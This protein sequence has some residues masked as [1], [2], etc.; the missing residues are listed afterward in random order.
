MTIVRD[1]ESRKSKGIA[2]VLFAKKEDAIKA[3]DGLN[4]TEVVINLTE[5]IQFCLIK[6]THFII[7]N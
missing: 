4:E 1:R 7:R 6:P 3:I 5:I 2:F